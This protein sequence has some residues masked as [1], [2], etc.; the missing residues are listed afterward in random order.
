DVFYPT[1]LLITGFDILF[2]WVARMIMLGCWFM[3]PPQK[4]T[5]DGEKQQSGEEALRN[6]V[7]FR[8]VYIHAL[9]R[10]AERQKMSKTK[11]NVLDPTEVI[12]RSGPAAPPF[13]LAAMAAPGTDTAF[14]PSRTEG[15]R[16]FANKIWNAARFLF[17]N[18]ER[19]DNGLPQ[20][21]D[22]AA[23]VSPAEK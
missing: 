18:M 10:D 7:P 8:E 5:R 23:G 21:N 11:G 20:H 19:V 1:S 16:N 3:M 13:P 15:Y 14:N 22:G 17:M 4:P 2:F 6:S 12:D 9:V